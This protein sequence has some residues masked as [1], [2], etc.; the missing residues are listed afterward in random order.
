MAAEYAAGTTFDLTACVT[1]PI[2]LLGG[3]QSNGTA[4]ACG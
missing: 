4:V 3:I 2:H 1:E